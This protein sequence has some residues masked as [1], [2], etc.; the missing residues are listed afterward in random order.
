MTYLILIYFI[1][2]DPL[3][4]SNF[5]RS[6]FELSNFDRYIK[7]WSIYLY[8]ILI[9]LI[10]I[11][12]SWQKIKLRHPEKCCLFSSSNNI[13]LLQRNRYS[14]KVLSYHTRELFWVLNLNSATCC[15]MVT[16]LGSS[17]CITEE[18][19]RYFCL[20][21]SVWEWIIL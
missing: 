12:L 5:D 17:Y 15:N 13:I 6:N 18:K 10:L 14:D 4:I 9:Y 3:S 16:Y 7:F 21:K 8:L 1:L 19:I 11:Y 20:I 2:I